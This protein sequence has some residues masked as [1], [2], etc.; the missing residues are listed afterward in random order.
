[1]TL[2]RY[3]FL[4]D[5]SEG[6]HPEIL[7]RLTQTNLEQMT[8]YGADPYSEKAKAF[9]RRHLGSE[10][11]AIYF[12]AGGTLA[13]LALIGHLLRPHEA[14][15]SAE[16]GHI[17][18]RE[19]GAIEAT[20]HKILTAATP[21]GKLTADCIQTL[22][23]ANS[24]VPHMVKP[25]LVYISNATE[26]GRFYTRAE[27]QALSAFCRRNDLLFMVDGARL[28]AALTATENDLT[29]KDLTALTDAFWIGGTKAGALLGEAIIIPR[30]EIAQDFAIHIK[31]RGALLAKG[32]LLGQQF[33]ALFEEDLF[34]QASRFA[35]AQANRLS[36]ALRERGFALADDTQTNQIFPLLP[37]TLIRQL[38]TRFQF[39]IW[40]EVSETQ[41]VLRL[42]T[43]WATD[44][45][46]V[47]A[48]IE[49]LPS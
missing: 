19:A 2:P 32:R 33:H 11:A 48:F 46:Q 29:L 31:L 5:Y 22:L 35:N 15:I 16:S 13:N 3:S 27:I 47:E 20:G 18:S 7:R 21:D 42:V 1:M 12:V 36:S 45:L 34:F 28:G 4:D 30:P 26:T 44:P 25:R 9:L 23:A 39:Y 8:A 38:E 40:K 41:A 17:V 37:K 10:T 49:M 6:C 14:V 24:H 43:S